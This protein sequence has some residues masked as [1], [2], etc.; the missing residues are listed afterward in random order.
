MYLI[1]RC[2]DNH[3][4]QEDQRTAGM[5]DTVR[6]VCGE[7]SDPTRHVPP[8]AHGRSLAPTLVPFTPTLQAV[9]PPAQQHHVAPPAPPLHAAAIPGPL[10]A[11]GAGTTPPGAVRPV[12]KTT[13]S[14][15][16]QAQLAQQASAS[17]AVTSEFG[18]PMEETAPQ[19]PS[20]D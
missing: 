3:W 14:S 11:P 13:D 12:L 20:H 19:S 10:V 7:W 4:A 18:T 15:E 2:W 16:R 17:A 8:S 5:H 1:S 9:Q 6:S